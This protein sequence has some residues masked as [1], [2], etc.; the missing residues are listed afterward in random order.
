M[1]A[2]LRVLVVDDHPLFREGVVAT[3]TREPGFE[4]VGEAETIAEALVR[5][6]L[7]RPDVVL[8]DVALPDGSGIEAVAPILAELP[9]T[10]IAVLTSSDDSDTVLAA[11]RAGAAGYLLKGTGSTELIAALR[12]ICRGES[13][14]S[15]KA[16]SRLL[17][18]AAH[19]H[20]VPGDDLSPRERTVLEMLG[21]GLTNREIAQKLYL[22]EK[23]VKRH[24]TVVMQKLGVRNRVEAALLAS[25]SRR[26]G[27]P[28]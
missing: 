2:D 25:R 5:V 11:L 16:A 8:L 4:V 19:P 18:E 22:S 7:T 23:T 24:V 17:A 20:P 9:A 10:R 15:P 13:Y 3:L 26:P 6:R 21:Q 28:R 14:T 12:A 1:S 27:Q